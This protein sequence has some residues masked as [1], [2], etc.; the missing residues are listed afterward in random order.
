MAGNKDRKPF[1][2]G[3]EKL[4]HHLDE[5]GFISYLSQELEKKKINTYE[6]WSSKFRGNQIY[7][8]SKPTARLA[9]IT[10]YHKSK[11]DSGFKITKKNTKF[12]DENDLL[13]IRTWKGS[14]Y[15]TLEHI[16]PQNIKDSKDWDNQIYRDGELL[17]NCLGNLTLLPEAENSA[18]GNNTWKLI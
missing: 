14:R 3:L 17:P 6:L 5:D 11:L 18:I 15:Q 7:N 9:L 13:N 8:V 10:C 12:S 4:N 2:V 1:S 16:A